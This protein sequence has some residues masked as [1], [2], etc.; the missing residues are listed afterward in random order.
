MK[1]RQLLFTG[2]FITTIAQAAGPYEYTITRVVDGDTVEFIMP[3]LPS[4]LGEKLK[5]RV[6]GVDTPEKGARAMCESEA[7]LGEKA[8]EFTKK[9]VKD[10]VVK[11]ITL[12]K[13]D[14]F[15][16][17][18]LGD[19]LLDGIPLSTKLIQAGLAR[20]YFGEKKQSWCE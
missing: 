18:V 16:G 10:A 11:E 7:K 20:P 9:A 15:G 5:I 12:E 8:T 6:L 19:V 14:K 1:I 2:L 17:R 3:G 4:E 13:W